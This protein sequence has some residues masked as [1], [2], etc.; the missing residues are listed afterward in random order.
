MGTRVSAWFE[1]GPWDEE[2]LG[3]SE[4]GRALLD[5]IARLG[6]EECEVRTSQVGDPPTTVCTMRASDPECNYGT[7]FFE[8][9]KIDKLA[10]AAGLWWAWGDEGSITW[11][12]SYAVGSPSGKRWSFLGRYR[13][14][15][16]NAEELKKLQEHHGGN[17]EKAMA[18]V[19]AHMELGRR[20]LAEWI[21][22]GE[23]AEELAPV[24]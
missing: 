24:G 12:A 1:I 2:A 4:P 14:P 10:Q 15:S 23:P 8:E 22:A 18:D 19:L 21:V 17:T 7:A 20:S 3:A 9:Q 6:M 5:V 16:I 11:E 13:N